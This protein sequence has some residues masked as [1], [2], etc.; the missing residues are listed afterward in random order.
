MIFNLCLC[1]KNI[2]RN[3]TPT[4]F[5][6][7]KSYQRPSICHTNADIVRENQFDFL[8]SHAQYHLLLLSIDQILAVIKKN[9]INL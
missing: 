4:D 1:N 5:K 9:Y 2:K 8:E 6:K 7:E 3:L